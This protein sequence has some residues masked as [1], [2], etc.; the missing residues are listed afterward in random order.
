[1]GA[2]VGMAL[3]GWRSFGHQ[4][5]QRDVGPRGLFCHTCDYCFS[6]SYVQQGQLIIDWN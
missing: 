1:M 5:L 4:C 3:G 2:L 6:E